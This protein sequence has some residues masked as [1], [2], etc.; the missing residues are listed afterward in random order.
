LALF[1]TSSAFEAKRS[2]E[3]VIEA[4]DMAGEMHAMRHVRQLPPNESCSKYVSAESLQW[5]KQR[6]RGM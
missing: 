6:K 4:E 2:V 3:R 5:E 1:F